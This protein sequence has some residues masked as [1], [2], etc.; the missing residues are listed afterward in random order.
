MALSFSSSPP[1]DSSAAASWASLTSSPRMSE[2]FSSNFRVPPVSP[3]PC[4]VAELRNW[5]IATET[6]R[7][8]NV[9]AGEGPFNI[10]H[11][12]EIAR[13]VR[14]NFDGR[15]VP[16]EWHPVIFLKVVDI[17]VFQ[18][19][20]IDKCSI[21]VLDVGALVKEGKGLANLVFRHLVFFNQ[22]ALEVRHT[23]PGLRNR[24]V[25]LVLRNAAVC[26]QK[27]KLGRGFFSDLAQIEE[28]NAECLR[29]FRD[30]FF[31]FPCEASA[32]FLVEQL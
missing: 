32:A 2:T 23:F 13:V 1:P 7:K 15:S 3:C 16:L 19:F 17:Q 22:D 8:A 25:Q 10:R 21:A 6:D 20:D 26:D 14:Q 24:M 12:I 30:G 4:P 9:Q 11:S 29:N 18:Q 28:G 5:D 27:I 31:I